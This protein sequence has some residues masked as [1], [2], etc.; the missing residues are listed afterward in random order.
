MCENW[1]LLIKYTVKVLM[2]TNDQGSYL[3]VWRFWCD[4]TETIFSR[5]WIKLRFILKSTQ[6]C[7]TPCWTKN[8][9]L[10]I[11]L[12]KRIFCRICAVFILL[13]TLPHLLLLRWSWSWFVRLRVWIRSR[14]SWKREPAT[15]V[16]PPQ[17]PREFQTEIKDNG[18]RTKNVHSKVTTNG[19]LTTAMLKHW[20][21]YYDT[22]DVL[23]KDV[24]MSL[25]GRLDSVV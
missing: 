21:Q 22:T 10:N 24:M 13:T 20:S 9:Q 15:I 14:K 17:T 23:V 11:I 6:S 5:Y 3:T 2:V 25:P 12:L 7:G 1:R 8:K 16:F 18:P 4:R 19:W